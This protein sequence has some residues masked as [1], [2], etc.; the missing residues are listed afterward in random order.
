[1]GKFHSYFACLQFVSGCI[2]KGVFEQENAGLWPSLWTS[3]RGASALRHRVWHAWAAPDP[4][5][6]TAHRG[7]AGS[8][9]AAERHLLHYQTNS[10]AAGPGLLADRHRRLQL[11]PRT[12]TGKCVWEQTDDVC[13]ASAQCLVLSWLFTERGLWEVT[14]QV[15]FLQGSGFVPKHA[16]LILRSCVIFSFSKS[17]FPSDPSVQGWSVRLYL[18]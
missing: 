2:V 15:S 13:S 7:S 18:I 11:V 1:M 6:A 4:A 8:Q 16:G 17:I 12:A 5:G 9:P 3:S 10:A 14:E